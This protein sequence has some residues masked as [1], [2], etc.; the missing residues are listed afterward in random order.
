VLFFAA[1]AANSTIPVTV[2]FTV[3]QPSI[4]NLV[5]SANDSL[6]D[7][8]TTSGGFIPLN[9]HTFTITPTESIPGGHACVT[10][11]WSVASSTTGSA[12][13][14]LAITGGAT[15]SGAAPG[16]VTYTAM[17]NPKPGPRTGTLTITAGGG[18]TVPAQFTVTEAGDPA[19]F[20]QRA[21]RAF[22]QQLL[23]RDPDSGGFTFWNNQCS[24]SASC[25]G[26]LVDQFLES[27][28]GQG[29]D[30]ATMIAYQGATGAAPTFAQWT[31]AVAQLRTGAQTPA[32]LL[33][34]INPNLTVA[35]LYQNLLGRAATA[36]ELGQS[37]SAA[38]TAITTS[39]E[40]RN[41]S[42]GTDHSN[43]LWVRLVYFVTVSRDPDTGGLQFWINQANTTG[44]GL[45]YNATAAGQPARI[46]ILGPGTPNQG[47][48]GSPE[49]QG[50]FN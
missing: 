14:W 5:V 15:G 20:N 30:M 12:A 18:A 36:T 24:T 26:Q 6:T 2:S 50:L 33:T 19:T 29:T 21:I 32:G 8:G 47:F 41:T 16:T 10:A 49:F 28:E 9:S 25:L 3:T 48:V 7:I 23:G 45:F 40:F 39:A 27:A 34:Q 13:N 17:G 38:Y 37:L 42:G 22:Y 31:A 1:G 46:A 43:F 4:C 11:T 44:P 35:Q